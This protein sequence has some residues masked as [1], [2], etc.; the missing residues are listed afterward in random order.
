L[1]TDGQSL[2]EKGSTVRIGEKSCRGDSPDI[3]KSYHVTQN[4]V[5]RELNRK[6]S[7]YCPYRALIVSVSPDG[8]QV[9]RR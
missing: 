3:R 8:S 7:G 6:C 2:R 1:S 5:R 9:Q 4:R